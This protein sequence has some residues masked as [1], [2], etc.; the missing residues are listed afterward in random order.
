MEIKDQSMR[1]S[2]YVRASGPGTSTGRYSMIALEK[3][4]NNKPGL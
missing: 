1:A 2:V 4:S 3:Y